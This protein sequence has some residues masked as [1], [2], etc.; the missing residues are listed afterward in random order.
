MLPAHWV[1]FFTD[2][3]FTVKQIPQIWRLITPFLIT[4]PKFGLLMD[5]YFLFTYG[6]G[7]EQ[8][9]PRFTEPGS[10]FIYNVFIMGTILVCCILL[11]FPS[12]AVLYA[13][14]VTLAYLPAQFI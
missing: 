13:L 9:S 11:A 8:G 12:L 6:S 7:L 1:V 5:P 3:I 4:G 14:Q 10:F 2:T